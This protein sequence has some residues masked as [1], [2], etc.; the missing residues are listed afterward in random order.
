[1]QKGLVSPPLSLSLLGVSW[2]SREPW[3][4]HNN[5]VIYQLIS[6]D[7]SVS[8]ST[9]DSVASAC[10]TATRRRTS[11]QLFAKLHPDL[12]AVFWDLASAKWRYG[13]DHTFVVSSMNFAR[14]QMYPCSLPWLVLRMAPTQCCTNDACRQK[15]P[16]LASP[17]LISQMAQPAMSGGHAPAMN[18][19]PHKV[20]TVACPGRAWTSGIDPQ[21]VW[22]RL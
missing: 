12:D 9:V 17:A 18:D 16:Q 13:R 1:M 20:V 22:K 4:S 15:L 8:L 11:L 7:S 21:R 2:T 5:E 3:L 6:Q 14:Q 19:R 10:L